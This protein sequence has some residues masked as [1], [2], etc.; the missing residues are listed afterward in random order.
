MPTI[1]DHLILELDLDPKG[2]D[3][4]RK[5]AAESF[6]KMKQDAE[7]G[8]K[9][10]AETNRGLADSFGNVQKRMM[11]LTA[12]F[13]GGMGMKE[14]VQYVTTTNNALGNLAPQIHATVSELSAWGGVAK[15][16]GGDVNSVTAAIGGLVDDL[17]RFSLTGE[18]KVVPVLRALTKE[19]G[20]L[21]V[22]VQDANGKLRNTTE[23][24]LDLSE[25]AHKQSDPARA[26]AVLRML[27]FDQ[28]GI[29]LMLRGRKF[30][31]ESLDEMRKI[32]VVTD[33]DAKAS[34]R[35]I[36]SWSKLERASE[37]LGRSIL[38][39]LAGPIKY[40]LDGLTSIFS[41][42]TDHQKFMKLS[43]EE[44]NAM[45]QQEQKVPGSTPLGGAPWP[46]WQQEGWG[47]VRGGPGA[48]GPASGGEGPGRPPAAPPGAAG[49]GGGAI[50]P[51]L[52]VG[53]ADPA[54]IRY[55]NPG[56]Q[57]PSREAAAFG[58]QGYGVIGGGHRIAGFKLPEH[59]A[60][61][62]MDL[63]RRK[64]VGMKIGEAGAKWTGNN[65]FGVP[66]YDPN[67]VVTPEM[68]ENPD[69]MIPFMKAIAKREAGRTYPMTDK[70]WKEAFDSY[71]KGGIDGARG[72]KPEVSPLRRD[73]GRSAPWLPDPAK[74]VPW[75]GRE[76]GSARNTST[77]QVHINSLNINSKK[78]TTDQYGIVRE[79]GPTL[80]RSGQ[81][82]LG[83]G[84][85]GGPN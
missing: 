4:G 34:A 26:A 19:N 74:D 6:L 53:G 76:Y 57:Y 3:E 70:R 55:N 27:G 2:F 65:S 22:Q 9:E 30:L 32:G 50:G 7:A 8:G 17:A 5:K 72:G 62:N 52:N 46:A 16:I 83:N 68:A 38:T 36:E 64:Y 47:G 15:K 10:I 58:Q 20:D 79:V 85:A 29:N 41:K 21:A 60:A 1:I 66:G 80:D 43:W 31:S 54:S 77:S 13:L 39:N 42:M 45:Q 82:G 40:V 59:G 44:R 78:D 28:T 84:I 69:F 49:G 48:G 81:M 56:A 23:I 61:A 33:E 14:F 18:S 35:L 25:W 63:F 51:Q 37:Q 71:R 75:L 24:L 73:Q 11:G 12:L 67:M